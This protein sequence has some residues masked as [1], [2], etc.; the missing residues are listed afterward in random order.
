M[1]TAV[2]GFMLF[3]L[4]IIVDASIDSDINE[5]IVPFEPLWIPVWIITS[6]VAICYGMEQLFRSTRPSRWTAPL[7]EYYIDNSL[8][9]HQ[10]ARRS[11][12]AVYFVGIVVHQYNLSRDEPDNVEYLDEIY[13]SHFKKCQHHKDEIETEKDL[14]RSE[15]NAL[16]CVFI[17]IL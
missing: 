14:T 16:F 7:L 9:G 3:I 2:L 11:L 4:A 17:P 6:F 5:V 8:D 12:A 15:I 1:S 13:Q 10:Q